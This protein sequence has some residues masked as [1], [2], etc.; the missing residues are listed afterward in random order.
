MQLIFIHGSGGCKESWK[1][2]SAH[3]AGSDAVDLPGHPSGA[4]CPTIPEYASW[5]RTYIHESGYSDVV[6]V[7]HSLGGGIALQYALDYPQD[8]AGVITVGSGG[9]LRVHPDFLQMMEKAIDEP[10]LLAGFLGQ[11][12]AGIDPA[13]AAVIERR[14]AENTARAFLNDFRACDRFD[15]MDQLAAIRVP[16]LAIVGD[17]DMM[18]PAKYSR[19]MVDKVPNAQMV[20]VPGGTHF[21][22]AEQPEAVNGAIE[23]FLRSL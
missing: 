23:A 14:T 10:S 2:Q 12:H 16:M 4:L 1:F 8:L 13:L 11:A 15:I 18:T 19:F 5:L 7:G 17:Q 22:F 20:V 9:R 6:L 3:F 21:V